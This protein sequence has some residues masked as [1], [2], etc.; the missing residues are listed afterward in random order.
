MT[1]PIEAAVQS[2][3][4]TAEVR[5]HDAKLQRRLTDLQ[6]LLVEDLSWVERSLAEATS[7]GERPAR[8]AARHLVVNAGKRI[9]PTALLLSAACFGTVPV[10]ARELGVV[11]EL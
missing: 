7:R 10:A 6:S 4:H 1:L 5:A 9:R 3:A 11:A 2:L 8:D